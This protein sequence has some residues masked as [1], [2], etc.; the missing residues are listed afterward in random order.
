MC[1]G[2]GGTPGHTIVYPTKKVNAGLNLARSHILFKWSLP[3]KVSDRRNSRH[4]KK[5]KKK[6]YSGIGMLGIVIGI[7][8]SSKQIL[9]IN[10]YLTV[11]LIF[12]YIPHPSISEWDCIF[13]NKKKCPKL[14]FLFFFFCSS[15]FDYISFG[16]WKN[17][18]K[19]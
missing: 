1:S 8:N 17:I 12:N 3:K 18:K 14:T 7:K 11:Y 13:K 15:T 4:S 16:N 2:G 5:Q 10:F 6:H 9:F 19:N